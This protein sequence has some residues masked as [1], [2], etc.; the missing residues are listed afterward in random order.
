M[1]HT[2]EMMALKARTDAALIARYD[3]LVRLENDF[4]SVAIGVPVLP[5]ELETLANR[6]V[7]LGLLHRESVVG[8]KLLNGEGADILQGMALEACA[9]LQQNPAIA[10]YLQ[11]KP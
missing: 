2:D 5:H 4:A 11:A 9:R 7:D 1:C 3:G 8:E 10:E 6:A